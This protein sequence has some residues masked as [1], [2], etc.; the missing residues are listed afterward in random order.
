M[1]E[2]SALLRACAGIPSAELRRLSMQASATVW[3]AEDWYD[4][5]VGCQEITH[6]LAYYTLAGSLLDAL[7]LTIDSGT[8]DDDDVSSSS[9]EGNGVPLFQELVSLTL[10]GVDFMR[11]NETASITLFDTMELRQT[12]PLCVTT[13]DRIELRACTVDEDDVDSLRTFASVVVW[14]SVTDVH[15]WQH[16]LWMEHLDEERDDDEDD[17]A[18]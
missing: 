7:E 12:S 16:D 1:V 11:A 18:E 2:P 6:V 3:S 9:S 10:V 8:D 15:S 17:E 14:D 4:T 5:F 13:L